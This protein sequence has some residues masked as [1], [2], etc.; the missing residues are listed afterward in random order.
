MK[1]DR[2]ISDRLE[3]ILP[4]VERPG[5]YLGG[6]VN[7]RTGDRTACRLSFALCFPD[8]YEVAMSHLGIQILYAVLNDHRGVCAERFFAPW[9]DMEEAMRGKGIPLCSLESR[10][11]L[12]S[13]D[14]IGFS[15]QYELAYTNVLNMLDLGG[16][17]LYAR[18]RKEGCPLVIAG[19]PCAFNPLPVAPFF[20]AFV[21]GEGEEVVTEVADALMKA[22]EKG[23]GRSE[24]LAAIAALEGVYVPALHREGDRV[25]KRAVRDLNDWAQ[26]RRPVVPVIKTI[27]DRVNLEIARGCTRGCRF[28]QAG[29]VW[30]PSR[31]RGVDVLESMAGEMLAATGCG[32][33]SLLSLS[34]GDYTRIEELLERLMD[35]HQ[36]ERVAVGLPSLRVETLTPRLIEEI[37]RVRKTSFTLAPEAGTQR[38]RDVINKGNSAED[39]MRTAREVFAAG[40]RSVKLYFMLGLPGEREED[41]EGI[42]DLAWRTLREGAMKRQVT[43]SVSTFVPK[44][45]TPFQWAEQAGIEEITRK[46]AF[47]KARLSHRNLAFKWHDARMSLLE[48]FFSRGD[49]EL[50]ALIERAFRLG[51][52]FDGWTDRFRFD[53]WEKA[54]EDVDVKPEMWLQGRNTSAALPWGFIDCGIKQDFLLEER[55]KA[56]D[57]VVTE[58]CRSGTCHKCGVC[59]GDLKI[60]TAPPEDTLP[61]R[62]KR[63]KD[64]GERRTVRRSWRIRFAKTGTSR[65]LSHLETVTALVRGVRQC[66]ISFVYSEGFHPHPRLSLTPALPV[67]VESLSEYADLQV[68]ERGKTFREM[69]DEINARLP[70]GLKVLEAAE[71]PFQ[72][73]PLSAI[74]EKA[75]YE[76]RLPRTSGEEAD[77]IRRFLESESFFIARTKKGITE[78][79]D[80][81]PL[82]EGLAYEAATGKVRFT[83]PSRPNGI[84][85]VDVICGIFGLDEREARGARI[86]KTETVFLPGHDRKFGQATG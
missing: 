86:V 69:L 77:R 16:I 60:I 30:R 74:I 18:D 4:F 12:S 44:P 67:G 84:R 11:P 3:D 65:F 24:R 20:D 14:V 61:G 46:Q 13:F 28:C 5:R 37:K 15:L 40:W 68:E 27:H 50:A 56:I 62:R 81:R 57:G 33:I 2:P 49:R 35:N 39:L 8:V 52:R 66:G 10:T 1:D 75:R 41:L 48:G 55:Q 51:C 72:A 53:L 63:E 32:E 47:L 17:P 85:P 64:N 82:L 29:M 6:E 59:T 22:G 71:I 9:P 45:H 34:T 19:G 21:I 80:V 31:E 73:A 83:V 36:R 26:P 23:G 79:K 58:D 76:V 7:S 43:V 25:R 42:A 54:M 38:L 70:S 78:K